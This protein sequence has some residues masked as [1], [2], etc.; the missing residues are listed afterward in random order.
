MTEAGAEEGTPRQRCDERAEVIFTMAMCGI[1]RIEKRGR[2][3]VYGLQIE[4]NRTQEDHERGRDFDR[5]DVDWEKTRDNVHLVRTENWNREI[6]RQIHAAGLKERKNSTVMLDGLYTASADWFAR[7]TPQEVEQYFRDC[8]AFHVREYCGGDSSRVIN[9]VI[10]LDE[11]TP[12]MQV[13]SVPIINDEKGAHLSAKMICGGR[14]DFRLHQNHFF[15]QVAKSRGLERGEVRDDAEIKAHTTKRE[16]QIAAQG[17]QI[18]KQERA[19]EHNRGVIS[20]QA[21]Q[22]NAA[23]QTIDKAKDAEPLVRALDA[24]PDSRQIAQNARKSLLSDDLKI[25]PSDLET[26]AQRASM[27]EGMAQVARETAEREKKARQE[28]QKAAADRKAAADERAAAERIKSGAEYREQAARVNALVNRYNELVPEYNSL[29]DG[30]D[31]LRQD[32]ADLKQQKADLTADV[33]R[34]RNEGYMRKFCR[35]HQQEFDAFARRE[36][37]IEWER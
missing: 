14:Q 12:H 16:W 18:A 24:A 1:M 9:A 19:I 27:G 34:I 33:E 10:H 5:S 31:A 8:L 3:A 20:K 25:S 22:Y 28:R 7:H 15:E 30:R 11:K 29:I 17:E 36:R 23:K 2:G 6:T 4:A 32:V 21:E 37:S 26:L 35:K 13:A